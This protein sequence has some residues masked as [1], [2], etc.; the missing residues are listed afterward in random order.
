M[1]GKGNCYDNT[2]IE[3]FYHTLKI[4]LLYGEKFKTRAETQLLV[5]DYIEEFYNRQRLHSTLGYQTPDE[6]QLAA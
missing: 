4:E 5:F 2:V 3:S 1:S 6:F